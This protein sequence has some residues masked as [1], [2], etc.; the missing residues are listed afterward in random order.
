[1]IVS[2]FT[3]SIFGVLGGVVWGI[4]KPPHPHVPIPNWLIT[5]VL[6]ACGSLV[7]S[8]L[9]GNGLSFWGK[10]S[11]LKAVLYTNLIVAIFLIVFLLY[12]IN[13]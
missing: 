7:V 4:I 10:A 9:I 8:I 2:L 3:C 11:L 5:L 12:M 1:M 6:T 13:V